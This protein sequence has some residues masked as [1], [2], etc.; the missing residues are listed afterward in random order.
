MKKRSIHHPIIPDRERKLTFW[1]R[2]RKFFDDILDIVRSDRDD[3]T[4]F[5]ATW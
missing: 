5:T 3:P 1:E 4:D 2:L